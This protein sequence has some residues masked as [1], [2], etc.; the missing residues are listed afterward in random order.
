MWGTGVQ[1]NPVLNLHVMRANHNRLAF[2][3]QKSSIPPSHFK[4]G[5]HPPPWGTI[6][7]F[8]IQGS[9]WYKLAINLGCLVYN[10]E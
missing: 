4:S 3:T 2:L 9:A 5:V 8:G 10:F 7:V 1:K 6:I